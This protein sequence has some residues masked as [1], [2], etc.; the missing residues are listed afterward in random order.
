[1]DVLEA[2]PLN[3]ISLKEKFDMHR[4]GALC[5]DYSRILNQFLSLYE[6]RKS[7]KAASSATIPVAAFIRLILRFSNY[8]KR[9]F[10][11]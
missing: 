11:V 4:S 10:F 2:V 3:F 6:D 5:Q 1:L 7:A 9:S 8:F